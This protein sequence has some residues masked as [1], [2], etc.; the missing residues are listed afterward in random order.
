M[1]IYPPKYFTIKETIGIIILPMAMMQ[2]EYNGMHGIK[3]SCVLEKLIAE[4][5]NLL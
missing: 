4:R 1:N 5:K 2:D 3:M